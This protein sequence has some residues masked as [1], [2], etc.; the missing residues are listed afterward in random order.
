MNVFFVLFYRLLSAN[1]AVRQSPPQKNGILYLGDIL[2][3]ILLPFA[4]LSNNSSCWE[5]SYIII[6]I[7]SNIIIIIRGNDVSL[8]SK[9]NGFLISYFYPSVRGE[10]KINHF[11]SVWME[12]RYYLSTW[13]CIMGNSKRLFSFIYIR[14][15]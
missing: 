11:K 1:K 15:V 6:I 12:E 4:R 3:N 8:H 7:F 14:N 2:T 9:W 5:K 10:T 13:N